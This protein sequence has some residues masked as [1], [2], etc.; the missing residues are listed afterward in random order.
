MS[1]G[2]FSMI[3]RTRGRNIVSVNADK[4]HKEE[5]G[6]LVNDYLRQILTSRPM[7]DLQRKNML[8]ILKSREA[9]CHL[10]KLIFQS[11]F[12]EQKS[13][14][15]SDESF[16]DLRLLIFYSLLDMNDK[17]EYDAARLITKSSFFYYKILNK[18]NY[19]LYKDLVKQ[20]GSFNSWVNYNFWNR[21]F[22]IEIKEDPNS[23][24]DDN[25]YLKILHSMAKYMQDLRIDMK[26]ITECIVETIAKKEN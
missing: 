20:N 10:S 15:L 2:N 18:E 1:K 9:R 23:T 24:D 19:F 14:C 6:N 13:H 22:D 25:F 4:K 3:Q 7:K 21:W 12:K 11:K 16:A 5:I 26:F 8:V 17:Y